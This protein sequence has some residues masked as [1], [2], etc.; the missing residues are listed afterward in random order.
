MWGVCIKYTWMCACGLCAVMKYVWY[1]M[2]VCVMRDMDMCVVYEVCASLRCK[3]INALCVYVQCE[4][5]VCVGVCM[6]TV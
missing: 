6:C 1:Q 3:G 5:Y 4:V 2:C